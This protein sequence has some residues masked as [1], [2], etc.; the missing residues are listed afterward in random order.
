MQGADGSLTRSALD[1]EA[2]V[3]VGQPAPDFSVGTSDG[4]FF[5]L[6]QLRQKASAVLVFCPGQGAAPGCAA[7]LASLMGSRAELARLGAQVFMISEWKGAAPAASRKDPRP[8]ITWLNDVGLRVSACYARRAAGEAADPRPMIVLVDK[9]GK[10]VRALDDR[11]GTLPPTTDLL[12][13][14]AGSGTPAPGS[15]PAIR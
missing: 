13:V 10:V 3:E 5:R 4:K 12:R 11:G 9:Q 7:R 15:P 1:P 8:A 6:I 2:L 14:L